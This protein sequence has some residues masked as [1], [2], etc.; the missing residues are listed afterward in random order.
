M[1]QEIRANTLEKN[2]MIDILSKIIEFIPTKLEEN[3]Q[4][5]NYNEKI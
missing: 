5:E 4:I 2:E 1:L 3:F